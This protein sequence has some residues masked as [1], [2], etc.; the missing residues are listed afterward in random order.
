MLAARSRVIAGGSSLGHF[1]GRNIV[2]GTTTEQLVSQ[3]QNKRDTK[4]PFRTGRSSLE[5]LSAADIIELENLAKEVSKR[6]VNADK[7]KELLP[8][9]GC[10]LWLFFGTVF[11]AVHDNLGWVSD[12]LCILLNLPQHRFMGFI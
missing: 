1:N 4:K 10:A 6:V 5:S 8:L 12:S 2:K 7:I 3:Q 11:Y 9:F